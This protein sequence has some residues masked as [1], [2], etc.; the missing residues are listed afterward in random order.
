M[1]GGTASARFAAGAPAGLS[2]RGRGNRGGPPGA[3]P[4]NRSIPAWAGEPGPRAGSA[5]C[6][7]VYPRVGGGTVQPNL[8]CPCSLGLSPRG[9]GNPHHLAG[10]TVP[11]RSIPAWAGEPCRMSRAWS[12]P[13]VYPRV[14]GG[15]AA[16]EESKKTKLGLS[17]RGRGNRPQYRPSVG[18]PGSIPAWAGE[19]RVGPRL[20]QRRG[21]YP[22]VGGGTW[23]PYR[24]ANALIGLS[25]RGRGNRVRP[26]PEVQQGGSIP[27]WAGEP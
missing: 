6:P 17:P 20:G 24:F 8:A 9:R 15:T 19:P 18:G 4:R 1:G 25:P 2:P 22:R 12:T 26:L 23:T 7:A 27:A 16:E 13:G 11:M 5:A 14:G 3:G 10:Q 21:V